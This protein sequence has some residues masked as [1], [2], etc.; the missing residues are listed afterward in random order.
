MVVTKC[1]PPQPYRRAPRQRLALPPISQEEVGVDSTIKTWPT[2]RAQLQVAYV[3]QTG[4]VY[5]VFLAN[6]FLLRAFATLG[7]SH[8]VRGH[9]PLTDYHPHIIPTYDARYTSL[10]V[11]FTFVACAAA[12]SG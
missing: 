9:C 7:L 5:S 2:D 10:C 3:S 6:T 4:S 8:T 1:V 11:E 12:Q